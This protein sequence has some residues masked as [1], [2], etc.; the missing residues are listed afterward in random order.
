MISRTPVGSV[1]ALSVAK[2]ND[3]LLRSKGNKKALKMATKKMSSKLCAAYCTA[4]C[5]CSLFHGRSVQKRDIFLE[6]L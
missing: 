6:A 1:V 4:Y 5:T 3:S 2:V